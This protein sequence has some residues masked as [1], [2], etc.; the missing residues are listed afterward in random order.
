MACCSLD[1]CRRKEGIILSIIKTRNVRAAISTWTL[2]GNMAEE[3]IQ[4]SRIPSHGS[5]RSVFPYLAEGSYLSCHQR[6]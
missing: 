4:G 6:S 5:V 3:M 1:L 2:T